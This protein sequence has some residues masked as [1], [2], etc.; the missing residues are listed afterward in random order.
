ME[1]AGREFP[2]VLLIHA[3]A[4][5]ADLMPELLDTLAELDRLVKRKGFV[6]ERVKTQ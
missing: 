4:L 2:Q 6:E 5:N 3:N 1:V